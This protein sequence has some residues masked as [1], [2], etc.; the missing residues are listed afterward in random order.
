MVPNNRTFPCFPIP[1]GLYNF[2]KESHELNVRLVND[3]CDE[4]EHLETEGISRSNVGGWHS[5]AMLD[6]DSMLQHGS[7]K[8]LKERIE[9][10]I[11]YGRV[12]GTFNCTGHTSGS[13]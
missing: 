11:P 6:R 10:C 9:E 5:D 12:I 3:I 1:V 4:M 7:F 2:G 13:A 8:I